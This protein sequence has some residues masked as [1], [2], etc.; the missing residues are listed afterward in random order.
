MALPKVLAAL[1][2]LA[3][4]AL[5]SE[6]KPMPA[7]EDAA[8]P[9][10]RGAESALSSQAEASGESQGPCDHGYA[11]TAKMLAPKC[12]KACPEMCVPMGAVAKAF[13]G[14][15][16][17]EGA[18]KELC[19]HKHDFACGFKHKDVCDALGHKARKMGFKMPM[20]QGELDG[21]CR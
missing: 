5:A 8:A 17:Q 20:S 14:K 10:L 6:E 15:G 7:E 2:V 13:L 19:S 1:T 21:Q 16:K 4:V 18:M 9:S 12:L 3:A 11:R